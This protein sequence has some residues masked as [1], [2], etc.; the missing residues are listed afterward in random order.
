MVITIGIGIYWYSSIFSIHHSGETGDDSYWCTRIET[1]MAE[2]LSRIK[3]L[4]HSGV[5]SVAGTPFSR[6]ITSPP[7]IVN[8][9][10]NLTTVSALVQ[11]ITLSFHHS[12]MDNR[13]NYYFLT[14][15][16]AAFTLHWFTSLLAP[17]LGAAWRNSA[18]GSNFHAVH[19]NT[20]TSP[21]TYS[22]TDECPSR[23]ARN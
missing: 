3:F 17:T 12:N 23:N 15:M 18:I 1:R 13:Q 11:I 19:Q 7:I 8:N 21:Q 2:F 10:Y 16:S 5:S 14:C 20:T 9:G 6:S 4:L 22:A